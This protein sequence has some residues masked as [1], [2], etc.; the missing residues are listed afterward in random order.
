[1]GWGG[2]V[3]EPRFI[4]YQAGADRGWYQVEIATDLTLELGQGSKQLEHQLAARMV[5]VVIEG[6]NGTSEH[7]PG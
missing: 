5:V 2:V 3:P 7:Q 1:V 4:G 6:T